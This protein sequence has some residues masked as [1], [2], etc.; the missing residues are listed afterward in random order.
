MD[1]FY[2]SIQGWSLDIEDM[3][4]DFVNS[5]QEGAHAVEVGVWKGRSAAFMCVEIANSGKKIQF[6]CVDTWLGSPIDEHQ[7]DS[8]VSSNSL[9]EHFTE[10][11]KSV[12]QYYKPVRLP[13]VEAAKLYEDASLDYVF[14]DAHH[15]GEAPKEDILAWLPKI[16]NGGILAG[17][18]YGFEGVFR[19]VNEI[20]GPNCKHL[21]SWKY[22]VNRNE[23]TGAVVKTIVSQPQ[24]IDEP[25]TVTNQPVKNNPPLNYPFFPKVPS[26]ETV[27]D[28][29]WF[30]VRVS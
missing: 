7:R 25:K 2:H 10:N 5:A 18:D 16:K 9:Y 21:G 29:G 28:F 4:R 8:Y 30:Q 13:S 24:Q 20:L 27:K 11:M 26:E 1:H 14:I 15:D 17:H 23:E 12:S 6:D 22:V 19:A 3:Y